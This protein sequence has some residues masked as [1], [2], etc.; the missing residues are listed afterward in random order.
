MTIMAMMSE[1]DHGDDDDEDDNDDDVMTLFR[2]CKLSLWSC[3]PRW[4]LDNR[5]SEIQAD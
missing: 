4:H 1:D 3:H 2:L 5:P